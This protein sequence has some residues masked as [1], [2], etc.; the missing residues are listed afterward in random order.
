M[1]RGQALKR[2][3]GEDAEQLGYGNKENISRAREGADEEFTA[4][5]MRQSSE[6]REMEAE[7][8][9]L[10]KRRDEREIEH[11]DSMQVATTRRLALEER[12]MEMEE[13]KFELDK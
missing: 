6:L 4:E 12:R 7:R 5:L 8:M 13:K 3:A 9:G 2:R 1:I 11:F 10:E